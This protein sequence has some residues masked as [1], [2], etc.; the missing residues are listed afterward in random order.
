MMAL[1]CAYQ[2]DYAPILDNGGAGNTDLPGIVANKCHEIHAPETDLSDNYQQAR[3]A[4]CSRIA[5]ALVG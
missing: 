3:L 1:T 5:S 2:S 4:I